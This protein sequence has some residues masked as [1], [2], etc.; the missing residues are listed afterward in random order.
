MHWRR[1][2]FQGDRAKQPRL[3]AADRSSICKSTPQAQASL[4]FKSSRI[5]EFCSSGARWPCPHLPQRTLGLAAQSVAEL[6]CRCA[7]YSSLCLRSES[8]LVVRSCPSPR[9]WL[10][11]ATAPQAASGGGEIR[12]LWRRPTFSPPKQ[13]LSKVTSQWACHRRQS[14]DSATK[15]KVQPANLR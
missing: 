6:L 9:R 12:R 10:C 11:S 7:F 4:L 13:R 1:C 5:L 14:R 15:S 2:T 3:H 8:A